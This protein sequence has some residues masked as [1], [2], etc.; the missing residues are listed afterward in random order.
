M[1]EDSYDE[2][3]VKFS[4]PIFK[5]LRLEKGQKFLRKLEEDLN[6]NYR[7]KVFKARKHPKVLEFYAE[8]YLAIKALGLG[9]AGYGVDL[10]A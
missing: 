1:T 9:S 7:N 2:T 8:N 10:F 5:N 6:T 3:M 4:N